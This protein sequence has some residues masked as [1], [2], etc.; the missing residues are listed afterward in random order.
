M[1]KLL[2]FF[3]ILIGSTSLV[4][5]QIAPVVPTATS[6]A[7]TSVAVRNEWNAFQNTAALAHIE[8]AEAS[9]QFENRFMLKE[10]S[11]RSIQGGLK[12]SAVNVGISY[13][14]HGYS[15]YHEMIG[16]VGI[17]RNFDDKFSMGVQFNYYTAYFSA[18]EESRYRG[19]LLT[20]FGV[21][22]KIFPKLTVGFHTFNPFQSSIKAE[23]SV[24]KL[25]SIFSIGTNYAFSDNLIWLTQIDKE[26]SSN[27][28]FATGFE[29]TMIDQVTVKLGA[30]AMDYLVPALGFGL[31]FGDFHI[32][33]NGELHPLLGLNTIANLKYS[34]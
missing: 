34:F 2:P 21:L 10:L 6:I 5:G 26:V 25:P 24:K 20:Q 15:V 11:T 9:V 29:Y 8:K 19:A 4:F 22:S 30:Y 16:G 1:R 23:N 14:F 33:L 32:H 31:H 13:S 7:N 18:D 27:F 17:A 3:I 12:T 28:R